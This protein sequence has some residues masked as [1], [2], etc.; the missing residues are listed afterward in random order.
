VIISV[1]ITRDLVEVFGA[2]GKV[3][4]G[5]NYPKVMATTFGVL[6]SVLAAMGLY[7]VMMYVVSQRTREIG[8]RLALGANLREL[9]PGYSQYHLR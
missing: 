8:I 4:N 7:S 1:I 2:V 6:A 3:T 5:S 9:V